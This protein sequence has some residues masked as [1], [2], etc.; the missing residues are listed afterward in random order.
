MKIIRHLL[1]LAFPFVLAYNNILK[2]MNREKRPSLRVL[3]Y[4]DIPYEKMDKLR[5]QLLW[6]SKRW[7]FLDP[8]QFYKALNGD[9]LIDRNSLLIT[10][11]DGLGSAYYAAKKVLDP[12]G[13]KGIFFV[14]SEFIEIE[15]PKLAKEYFYNNIFPNPSKMEVEEKITSM[16]WKNLG[17]LVQNGHEVGGHTKSHLRLTDKYPLAKLED[18]ILNS[19]TQIEERLNID[20]KAF[21]YTFG[22]IDSFS[23]KAMKIAMVKY[24]YIFSGLR[25]D[26][27]NNKTY[28]LIMRDA[29]SVD[30][31]NWSLGAFLLGC[32]DFKYKKSI[33]TMQ[34]WI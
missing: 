24:Q 2:A 4:H 16:S 13:L 27:F 34:G 7:D 32:A 8:K 15:N 19:A 12:L 18:E 25:G 10:F 1:F 23:A 33:N 29:V 3:I 28:R 6:L 31:R 5:K 14:V 22:D 9:I 26:N 21:A 30:E 20:L 11:D 17:D